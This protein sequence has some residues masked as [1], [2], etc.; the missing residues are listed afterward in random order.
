MEWKT[1]EHDEPAD[2][3]ERLERAGFVAEDHEV[4]LLGRCEDLVHDVD[5]PEG[6]RLRDIEGDEDWERVRVMVDAV[7][8]DRLVVGQ[9]QPARR[10]AGRGPTS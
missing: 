10:A 5:L 3:P 7:W 9:R 2:L 4:V 8:G 1:Y 6:R